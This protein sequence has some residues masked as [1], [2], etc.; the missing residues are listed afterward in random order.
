MAT[1]GSHID[2]MFL[3]PPYPAAGSTTD[4]MLDFITNAWSGVQC[5][6]GCFLPKLWSH[7]LYQP[8]EM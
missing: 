3:G 8:I 6:D 2:F 1:K 4:T 7:N 5:Q